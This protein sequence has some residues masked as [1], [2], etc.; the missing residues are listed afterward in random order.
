MIKKLLTCWKK[1][2]R[3]YCSNEYKNLLCAAWTGRK[4]K[5]YFVRKTSRVFFVFG[6]K[7]TNHQ[8]GRAPFEAKYNRYLFQPSSQGKRKRQNYWR[9]FALTNKVFQR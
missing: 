8:R 9:N 6:R 5:K 4:S 3:K 1:N 2:L 7:K